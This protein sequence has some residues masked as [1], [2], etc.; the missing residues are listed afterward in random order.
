MLCHLCKC[1]LIVKGTYF[2]VP[3]VKCLPNDGSW[4]N[5]CQEC[6]NLHGIKDSVG[7]MFIYDKKWIKV[8][9]TNDN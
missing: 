4:Y 1:D 2:N 6:Y 8:K 3:E 5:L 7:Q 9:E